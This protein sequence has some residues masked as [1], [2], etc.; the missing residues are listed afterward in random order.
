MKA[1]NMTG[2]EDRFNDIKEG[3][4]QSHVR[5]PLG[6]GFSRDYNWPE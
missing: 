3:K 5:E 4:Y 6:S 1:Q 2:M